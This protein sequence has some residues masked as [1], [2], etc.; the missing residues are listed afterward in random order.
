VGLRAS[1]V[2]IISAPREQQAEKDGFID[3]IPQIIQIGIGL[4]SQLEKVLIFQGQLH[5]SGSQGDSFVPGVPVQSTC[6]NQGTD[7]DMGR[8]FT[9]SE[10]TGQ[11]AE[12]QRFFGT[13]D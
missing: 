6:R 13:G 8:A 2:A 5:G 12:S 9:E 7:Q 11:I 1:E 4:G 3:E 10:L